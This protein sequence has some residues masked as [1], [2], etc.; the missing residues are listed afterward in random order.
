MMKRSMIVLML[1]TV[2]MAGFRSAEAQSRLVEVEASVP[3][4]EVSFAEL[5]ASLMY[6]RSAQDSVDELYRRARRALNG[7]AYLD[8]ASVFRAIYR[9]HPRH[10]YAAASMYWEAY[11]RYRTRSTQELD[12]ARRVIIQLQRQHPDA[13]EIGEAEQLAVRIQGELARHGDAQAAES[14]ARAAAPPTP[15]DA[16]RPPRAQGQQ[17]NDDIRVAA[18]NALMQMDPEKALPI[19]QKVLEDRSGSA[20]FRAK[21]VFIVSQTGADETADILLDVARSDPDSEVRAQAVF[22]LSQVG[23]ARAV[24]ALD[25]ILNETDD[26]IVQ[27]K[28]I[29]ALSQHSS[30]QAG[31]ALRSFVRR[32]DAP[33]ELREKAIFWL[34]QHQAP[35]NHVFLRELYTS[36]ESTELK[37]R[38]LFAVAQNHAPEN[39]A[40]LMERAIDQSESIELRK[41]AL[42]WAGQAGDLDVAQLDRLYSTMDDEE[43][44]AQVIFVAS[45]RNDPAAV[46]LLMRIAENDP[47]EELQ[48]KAVFWLGQT[49]DPR[50]P[51]FLLKLINRPD[52]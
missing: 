36:L 49:G 19:L 28:A 39:G 6:L 3:W 14:V 21:A 25:S 27:E 23:G 30:D 12:H 8:A 24:G 47:N 5:E 1:T 51:E 35:E 45:Q 44:R 34:G 4:A 2:G 26:P 7:G 48:S 10:E 20:E 52:A 22:W 15:P 17:A 33:P 32:D 40:W 38:V 11:S 42:F 18:L 16:P 29:F 43:M 50:V 31:A 9:D 46:D 13:R 37:E 41:R